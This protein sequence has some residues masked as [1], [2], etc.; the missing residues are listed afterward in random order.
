VAG[1]R[2]FRGR[3]LEEAIGEAARFLSVPEEAVHYRL[4]DEGRLGV[5]G[6]GARPV[7]IAVETADRPPTAPAPA[8][9]ARA[10]LTPRVESPRPSSAPTEVEAEPPPALVETVRAIL[11]GGAFAVAPRIARDGRGWS[12]V[13]EGEDEDLFLKR[14]AELLH[15]FEFLLHRMARRGWPDAGPVRVRCGAERGG[16]DGEVAELAREVASVVARTGKPRR[17]HPMNP[18]E[19]RIVHVTVREFPGLTSRSEGEG[20]LKRVT[21]AREGRRRGRRRG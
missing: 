15:A 2:E 12:I 13:L 20:F 16:D 18:Y 14:D 8:A 3:T 10:T 5:L 21:V 9:N 4:V 6:F 19:R 7:R 1:E 17:L 11:E